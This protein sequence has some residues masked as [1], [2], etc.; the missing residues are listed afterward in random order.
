MKI[1]SHLIVLSILSLMLWS[2]NAPCI[3]GEGEIIKEKRVLPAFDEVVL[4]LSAELE[5]VYSPA[6]KVNS[7]VITAQENLMPY[8]S[9]RVDGTKLILDSDQ[10]LNSTETITLWIPVKSLNTITNSGSGRILGTSVL[11]VSSV[12]VIN[13]GSGNIDIGLKG[14]EINIENQGSGNVYIRGAVKELNIRNLGSGSVVLPEMMASDVEINCKG[15]GEVTVWATNSIDVDLSGSGSVGYKGY[16]AQVSEN[17]TG[18][19]TIYKT[20][21]K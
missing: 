10:C 18:S 5:I 11:P 17:N 4:N 12:E 14:Q 8:I 3:E 21:A 7:I 9:A 16:P 6:H 13:E 19:G 2:C 15:S 1:V 20:D